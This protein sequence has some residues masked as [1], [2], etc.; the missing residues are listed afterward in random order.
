MFEIAGSLFIAA[1]VFLRQKA[2]QNGQISLILTPPATDGTMV[3]RSNVPLRAVV[4]SVRAHEHKIEGETGEIESQ[5]RHRP[6]K[7]QPSPSCP[8]PFVPL[9]SAVNWSDSAGCSCL[10]SAMEAVATRA[11]YAAARTLA[12]MV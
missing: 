11:A 6:A 5:N 1:S 8:N 4:Q 10:P 12:G 7:I 9:I 3:D 2:S